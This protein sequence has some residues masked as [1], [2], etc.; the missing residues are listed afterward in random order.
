MLDY[1]AL[2]F[3]HALENSIKSISLHTDNDVL[4][5]LEQYKYYTNE[6]LVKF[7]SSKVSFNVQSVSGMLQRDQKFQKLESQHNIIIS[8][9]KFVANIYFDVTMF[10]LSTVHTTQA[11][12]TEFTDVIMDTSLNDLTLV[13]IGLT[14]YN[15]ALLHNDSIRNYEPLLLF[16]R[17]L[18]D[19]LEK[20]A[21]DIHFEVR[22]T[23]DAVQFPILYRI[24]GLLIQSELF[25][26]NAQLN[27]SIISAL[28]EKRTNANSLDLH[29]SSGVTANSVS[30]FN[31]NVEL[32][33]SANSVIGG[34]HYVVRIQQRT[35]VQFTIDQLGFNKIIQDELH[36]VAEKQSG[37]TLITGAIRTGK[38]TTAFAIANEMSKLPV[39]IVSYESPIEVMMPFPQ[40]DY[41][42]DE[43]ILLNTIR[44]A[45]KQ[46]VNIAF[47]NE[48]PSKEVAFA[49]RDLV[50]SS[51]HVITTMHLN[52]IWHLPYRLEEYYGDKYKSI[53]SQINVVFNQKMFPK[54]C[55]HCR[56]EMMTS[57]LEDLRVQKLL[58]SRGINSFITSI[59]C[60]QCNHTGN[61]PGSNQPYVEMIVFTDKLISELLN[62]QSPSEMETILHT[63]V[64]NT[65]LESFMI[66]AV[67]SGD[68]SSD[69]LKTLV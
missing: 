23:I 17:I 30:S 35:T 55:P 60:E 52:R 36:Y 49:V 31:E 69:A 59:G 27:Q 5:Y 18:L 1:S 43:T 58:L 67:Q 40:V 37:I 64:I 21:T 24:N 62:C 25:T 16:E 46:D 57:S 34:Y 12:E 51:I 7:I 15:F 38:N 14:P 39:K 54:R 44:L 6:Q 11:V 3:S 29:E 50:N 41:K 26:L 66:P 10:D 22:H 56:H 68:L 42:A 63:A 28:I 9:D 13:F 33:I 65:S 45:K 20:S 48:I 8:L 19:A 2:Q 61:V 32:R 4:Y 47:I 53:I